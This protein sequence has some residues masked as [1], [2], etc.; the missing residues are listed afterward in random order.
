MLW[1]WFLLCYIFFYNLFCIKFL[2]FLLE[3]E[4]WDVVVEPLTVRQHYDDSV[5]TSVC[6]V[7]GHHVVQFV[8]WF[9]FTNIHQFLPTYTMEPECTRN[10]NNSLFKR[11]NKDIKI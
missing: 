6:M 7:S 10:N 8:S 1:K 2:I 3:V 4:W 9:V 11:Y 5:A